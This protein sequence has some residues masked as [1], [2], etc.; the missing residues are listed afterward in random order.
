MENSA[1]IT[2]DSQC[3]LASTTAWI[4]QEEETAR[5]QQQLEQAMERR[6]QLWEEMQRNKARLDETMSGIA[7]GHTREHQG[8]TT[9][10]TNELG[11]LKNCVGVETIDQDKSATTKSSLKTHNSN[12]VLAHK[13]SSSSRAIIQPAD[14]G[15]FENAVASEMPSAVARPP[16]PQNEN[17]QQADHPVGKVSL[18]CKPVCKEMLDRFLSQN[19]GQI[20]AI[21]TG[22]PRTPA[23][24]ILH[25]QLEK[26]RI[27]EHIQQQYG[28]HHGVQ[29]AHG[30]QQKF[31]ITLYSELLSS[32]RLG[33]NSCWTHF[34]DPRDASK[35]LE[36][37]EQL[38]HS[39]KRMEEEKGA[40]TT[41]S[42]APTTTTTAAMSTAA[43]PPSPQKRARVVDLKP[44]E[45]WFT[46]S[47]STR[48]NTPRAS[49]EKAK[50]NM[51]K[52]L[53][54]KQEYELFELKNEHQRLRPFP[55]SEG[56]VRHPSD[57]IVSYRQNPNHWQLFRIAEYDVGRKRVQ[58]KEFSSDDANSPPAGF[59][60]VEH[61]FVVRDI[62]FKCGVG[63]CIECGEFD[64]RELE[65]EA[66][67][68]DSVQ[69]EGCG[70]CFHFECVGII[71]PLP[72][73][74]H[75]ICYLCSQEQKHVMKQ[76]TK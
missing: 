65:D 10:S 21:L 50:Q 33:L 61:V 48:A 43:S 15:H 28:I 39:F 74:R 35:A 23:H 16:V 14:E 76:T 72:E 5:L 69:C 30:N 56:N 58:L 37:V 22:T 20:C 60:D 62:G 49:A 27:P 24:E 38:L 53:H 41:N 32:K 63:V 4:M 64:E 1:Q 67:V 44:A 70:A 52:Q 7:S 47:I 3:F 66:F 26:G 13:A 59:V 73:N 29:R 2:A 31:V 9:S 25:I 12:V 57:Q 45:V 46:P 34:E 42:A 36:N 68:P 71:P 6:K 17:D 18:V 51:G 54:M 40:A 11:E 55:L 8:N 75:W 19:C